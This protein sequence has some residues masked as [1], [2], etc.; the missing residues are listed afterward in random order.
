MPRDRTYPPEPEPLPLPVQDCHTHAEPGQLPDQGS[1]DD[2][3]VVQLTLDEQVE[4]AA[5]VGISGI[6]QCGCDLPSAR[7]TAQVAVANPA[8]LGA[9]AIHPNDSARLLGADPAGYQSALGEIAE[10]AAS[11]ERIRAIGETGLDYYRT[12]DPAGRAAQV[13]AFRDH[14]AL[15]KELG[16]AMQIHD[17]DAH[18]DCIETLERDGAP[19]RTVFHCFSGDREMAALA[20]AHGWWL[21]VG[22]TVT[23]KGNDELRAAV[24]ATPLTRLLVETDAPYLTPVPHRGR[25]N[26]PY[27]VPLTVRAIAEVKGLPVEELCAALALNARMVYGDW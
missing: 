20:A 6:V 18:R 3:A 5:R 27:L 24:A 13:R 15:A 10:L 1:A 19:D 2:S 14:I 25:P 21:Q 12:L 11:G 9:I 17:R 4:R 23:F 8:V 16:R 26:A 22:G 7:W